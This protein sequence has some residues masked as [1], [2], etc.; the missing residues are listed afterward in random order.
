MK[1]SIAIPTYEASGKATYFL[2]KQF[3]IFKKQSMSEFQV[4]ISDHSSDDIVEKFCKSYQNDL[5]IKYVKYD[6]NKGNCSANT[7]NA[8]K[9]CDGEIIKIIFQDDFLWNQFSLEKVCEAF[10]EDTNWMVN[11]CQHTNDDGRTYFREFYPRYNHKIHLGINTLS[12]PTSLTIRNLP[13]IPIFDERLNWLMDVDLYKRLYNKFGEP[14]ILNE[15]ITVNRIWGNQ[16]T[17]NVSESLKNYELK[18]MIEKFGET[19]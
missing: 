3:S 1:L 9:N 5:N 15:I 8:I 6:L 14:K 4:V 2:E 18:L 16:L 10:T 17:N 19:C 11:A 12:C 7:N 13:D